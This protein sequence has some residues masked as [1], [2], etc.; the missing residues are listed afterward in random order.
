MPD[1]VVLERATITPQPAVDGTSGGDDGGSSGGSGGGSE[2]GGG[3]GGVKDG[4]E[5]VLWALLSYRTEGAA[6]VFK[7]MWNGRPLRA[8]TVRVTA[9]APTLACPVCLLF[10]CPCSLCW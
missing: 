3:G 1:S 7:E 4:D 8:G 6:R 5:G 2:G 9:A 10:L